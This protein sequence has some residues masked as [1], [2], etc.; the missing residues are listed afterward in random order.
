MKKLVILI[1]MVS[2]LCGCS[3][4][5]ISEVDNSIKVIDTATVFSD[6]NDE[7]VYIIDVREEYEYSEGH[8]KNA[9]NVPL[10]KLIVINEM[11]ISL[12][13]KIIVYCQSGNRSGLAAKQLIEMGYTN[14]YDMGGI[15]SWNYELVKE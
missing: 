1:L 10:T 4:N 6:I 5:N 7:N 14:V 11:D 12:D 8:I 3:N 9:Y 15:N 13:S 2:F